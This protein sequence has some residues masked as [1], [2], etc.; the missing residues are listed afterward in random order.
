MELKIDEKGQKFKFVYSI[1]SFLEL[2]SVIKFT[3]CVNISFL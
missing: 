2:W 1:S 3:E